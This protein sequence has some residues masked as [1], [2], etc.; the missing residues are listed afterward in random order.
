MFWNMCIDRSLQIGDCSRCL[1]TVFLHA[2][3]IM[4]VLQC[5]EYFA[6]VANIYK[7]SY[8]SGFPSTAVDIEYLKDQGGK[9]NPFD[10]L[11]NAGFAPL[12]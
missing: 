10:L 8:R 9:E 2:C 11:S 7:A 1:S 5:I 12:V 3:T 4:Q 6:G